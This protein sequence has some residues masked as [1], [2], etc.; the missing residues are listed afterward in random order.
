MHLSFWITCSNLT[1]IQKV[2]VLAL[3]DYVDKIYG[4]DSNIYFEWKLERV[5]HNVCV[6][7]TG[8]IKNL[9]I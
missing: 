6:A 7:N 1:V 2:F 9:G 5:N 8:A 4:S 3:I